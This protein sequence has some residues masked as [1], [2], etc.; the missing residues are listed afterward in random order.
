MSDKHL[1]VECPVVSNKDPFGEYAN[2]FRI[3][4]DGS[5]ML[6]DF[7]VYSSQQGNAKLVSR[8]RVKPGL[9]VAI[10]ERINQSL[11][12]EI[13]ATTIYVMPEV[14]GSQ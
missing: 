7:C 2:A 4:E 8:V 3:L 14:G 1:T 11:A 6:L 9:A 13:P 5:D 12:Q 10:K